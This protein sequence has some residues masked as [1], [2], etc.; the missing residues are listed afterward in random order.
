MNKT[1]YNPD[2]DDGNQKIFWLGGADRPYGFDIETRFD[3]GTGAKISDTLAI[4]WTKAAI[5]VGAEKL[6]AIFGSHGSDSYTQGRIVLVREDGT[7]YTLGDWDNLGG[8]NVSYE[9]PQNARAQPLQ[10]L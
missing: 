1:T 7:A 4:A 10:S 2:G 8:K 6:E 9:S 3:T 5:P